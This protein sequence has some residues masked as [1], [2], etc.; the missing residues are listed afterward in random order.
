M[1]AFAA[2]LALLLS[3]ANLFRE[4]VNIEIAARPFTQVEERPDAEQGVAFW[5][6]RTISIHVSNT[7][8]RHT[9]LLDVRVA[10]YPESFLKRLRAP[11]FTSSLLDRNGTEPKFLEPGGVVKLLCFTTHWPNNA[12]EGRFYAEVRHSHSKRW[13]R[14]RF[15]VPAPNEAWE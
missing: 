3:A 10:G 9:T 15:R 6:A 13:T 8:R 14:V 11:V 1:N 2:W 5:E 4:R 7:G 12:D